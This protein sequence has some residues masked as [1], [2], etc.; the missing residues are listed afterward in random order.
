MKKYFLFIFC[1]FS[2]YSNHIFADRTYTVHNVFPKYFSLN[3][4]DFPFKEGEELPF[5]IELGDQLV[6]KKFDKVSLS[7]GSYQII[8][9]LQSPK[10]GKLHRFKSRIMHEHNAYTLFM[11]DHAIEKQR[12]IKE[13]QWSH[14]VLKP[15]SNHYQRIE[16][17]RY[18]VE[19]RY[20]L[21]LKNGLSYHVFYRSP[22]YKTAEECDAHFYDFQIIEGDLLSM[23]VSPDQYK[24]LV[25][26]KKL[27]FPIIYHQRNKWHYTNDNIQADSCAPKLTLLGPNLQ[28]PKYHPQNEFPVTSILIHEE[29][30]SATR[31]GRQVAYGFMLRHFAAY[32]TVN[33]GE[34][35]KKGD[36]LKAKNINQQ[37]NCI[38][39]DS[40]GR[41]IGAT[42]HP[43]TY[44]PCNNKFWW[45]NS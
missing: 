14:Y 19:A 36:L 31:P 1:F 21:V 3:G 25:C 11:I 30:G 2:F 27:T 35:P 41:E 16:E 17:V 20:E 12:E 44:D 33:Q 45:E 28:P 38:F 15:S 18:A 10:N 34:I 13:I 9:S 37:G 23:G 29:G 7:G 5:P 22:F 42:I 8:L 39:E 40:N 24:C 26:L 6:M 43:L 4:Y 32:F